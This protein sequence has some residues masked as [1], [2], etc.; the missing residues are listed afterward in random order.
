MYCT[1]DL[2]KGMRHHEDLQVLAMKAREDGENSGIFAENIGLWNLDPVGDYN[3]EF[4]LEQ[5]CRSSV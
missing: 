2:W 4:E 1:M 5:N 3:N